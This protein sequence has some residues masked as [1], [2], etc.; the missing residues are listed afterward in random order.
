MKTF[1]DFLREQLNSN[2]ETWDDVIH[3]D[4]TA[5]EL[6]KKFYWHSIP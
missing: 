1:K 3:H 5:Y 4:L 2:G 6:D